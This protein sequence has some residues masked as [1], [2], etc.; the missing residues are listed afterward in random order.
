MGTVK[1]VWKG[2]GCDSKYQAHYR[3]HSH[4][5]EILETWR[6]MLGSHFE[7]FY[8]HAIPIIETK[9]PDSGCSKKVD[10]KQPGTI[11]KAD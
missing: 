4:L 6:T 3:N 11:G 9:K 1:L 7:K 10:N 2:M 8:I 5:S